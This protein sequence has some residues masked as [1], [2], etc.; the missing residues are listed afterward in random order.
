VDVNQKTGGFQWNLLGTYTFAAGTSGSVEL[1]DDANGYVIADAVKFV[2]QAP[3]APDGVFAQ[4][5]VG[6]DTTYGHY[7]TGH[8]HACT[9]CHDSGAEHIDHLRRTYESA[10]DNYD[11]GF[12]LKSI[13]GY[14][15][16]NVPRKRK[17][18]VYK[19]LG[20]FALCFRCHNYKE[21]LGQDINDVSHT[22]F[23]NETGAYNANL[24]TYHL[25]IQDNK[26]T[27]SDRNGTGDTAPTCVGCH[28]VHGP[29]NQA[30]L[31]H[32]ELVNGGHIVPDP[33]AALN[34]SYITSIGPP[35]V[36]S[37]TASLAASVGGIMDWAGT[38][39]T[40]NGVCNA[41][42][43][44]PAVTYERTAKLWPKVLNPNAEPDT[45]L[46]TGAGSTLL[47]V[48][49]SDPDGDFDPDGLPAI[50]SLQVDLSSVGGSS[51]QAMNDAGNFGDVTPDDGTYSYSH[52][53]PSLSPEGEFILSVTATD[54]AAN[55]GEYEIALAVTAPG[56]LVV[57]N[58]D[59]GFEAQ[60]LHPEPD[61]WGCKVQAGAYGAA[62]TRCHNSPGSGSST[63]TWIPDIPSGGDYEVYA[64]WVSGSSRATDAPYTIN[65]DGGSVTVDVSQKTDG[66]QWNLLGTYPFAA[67]TSGSIVLTDD[68]NGYVI[69]DA[70]KL[71]DVTP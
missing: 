24:H 63:A 62:S 32:G 35:I 18:D 23:W 51:N 58:T 37:P 10:L 9:V 55:T 29:P 19:V 4:D 40:Y 26:H 5:V 65:Y 61:K 50:G 12:R 71:L 44:G 42:C 64:W 25:Q 14:E 68:A 6:D 34:F 41:L 30:M 67:G 56:A 48:I 13:N 2:F 27:D 43:H 49:V 7:V 33:F 59:A 52:T 11:D 28:N 1:S 16:M 57:D 15:A 69:A 53:I 22:N 39:P 8:K 70:V 3:D 66:S 21:V 54:A 47:T 20:D 31:R 60:P 17:A 45:V 46:N 38:I 36:S